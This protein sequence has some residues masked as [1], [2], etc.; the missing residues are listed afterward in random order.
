MRDIVIR[1]VMRSVITSVMTGNKISGS[2]AGNDL[3]GLALIQDVKVF[4]L[5]RSGSMAYNKKQSVGIIF[6]LEL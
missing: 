1:S 2:S 5:M 4:G 6:N 3:A